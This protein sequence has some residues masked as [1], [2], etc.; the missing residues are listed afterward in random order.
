VVLAED[1]VLTPDFLFIRRAR[2]QIIGPKAIEGPPDIV[3]EILSPT[4]RQRDLGIRMELY[5]RFGV[6]EY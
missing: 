3:V 1:G 4:T 6:P 5:A 2:R